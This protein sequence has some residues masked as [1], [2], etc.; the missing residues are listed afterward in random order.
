MTTTPV[1]T[2]PTASTSTTGSTNL[3]LN[4]SDF[5]Q[6][7]ITQLQ[8]QDPLNPTNSDALMQ[9]MSEIGQMQSTTQ[10]QSTLSGLAT[11]T[12]IGAASNL[13]GKQISGLDAN[14]NPASGIVTSVQ[15]SSSGVN[16]QLN[17]GDTVP[18]GS[19]ETITPATAST[20]GTVTAS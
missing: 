19:V 4:A 1:A 9:E 17:S 3:N 14:N 12:Q 18:L 6:M 10:L 7:M 15:V 20:T 2:A 16:L 8:N 11:Q 13:L 5:M